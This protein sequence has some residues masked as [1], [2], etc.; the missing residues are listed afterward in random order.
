MPLVNVVF[1]LNIDKAFTYHLPS[2]FSSSAFVGQRVLVPF[3]KREIT[4]IIVKLNVSA[5]RRDYK[6]VLDLLDSESLLDADLLALTRWMAD[7]YLAAWGQTLQLA[8][9]KGLEK[10]SQQLAVPADRT[11]RPAPEMSDKQ[12]EL[13][14]TMFFQMMKS[15]LKMHGKG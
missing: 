11:G 6:D 7:Y 8:L 3:G 12:H 10:K 1:N 14:M 9:P 4:G 2:E 15:R 13:C 5:G